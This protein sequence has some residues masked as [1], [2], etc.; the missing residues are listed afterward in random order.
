MATLVHTWRQ[1]LMFCAVYPHQTERMD[2]DAAFAV[3]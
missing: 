3:A 2:G 1:I